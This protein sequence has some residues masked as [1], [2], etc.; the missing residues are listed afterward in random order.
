LTCSRLAAYSPTC[1]QTAAFHNTPE[2]AI[3]DVFKALSDPSRRS[4]LD[5]LNTRNGQSLTELCAGLDMTRQ[6]V[7]KHLAVLE[8]ATLVAAVRRGRE[9]LHYLN[10]APINEIA[11]RWINQY[12]HERVRA[13]S[14]LKS[15]LEDTPMT[16]PEF[17]YVTYIRTT[18]EDLWR[19]LTE[20]AFT[21]RYWGIA[22]ETDW[23]TG[24]PMTWE[25]QNGTAQS[26]PDQIVLEADPY[27]HLAYAWHA[28]TPEWNAT[29]GLSDEVLAK[30]AAEPRSHVSFDIEPHGELVKLT[31]VHDN[32][33]PGS[34]VATMVSA[35]WPMVLSSL[36]TLLETGDAQP[37]L[38]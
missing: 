21:R 19:A 18:A 20:P 16:K 38:A 30:V 11:E 23:Q 24:S 31:V 29:I 13:L 27:R 4:L 7:T 28:F 33:E 1:N 5:R 37:V 2:N 26:D 9:K 10:T 6:S 22:H 12:D 32:F 8:A 3:D 14:D 17:V 15:A 36:K 35:G 25:K 34:T